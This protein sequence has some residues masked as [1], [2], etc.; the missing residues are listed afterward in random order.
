[1]GNPL[2]IGGF[3]Q[4]RRKMLA[5]LNARDTGSK[6]TLAAFRGVSP[7]ISMRVGPATRM[8]VDVQ[9]LVCGLRYKKLC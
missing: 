7:A 4:M 8:L 1:M 3:L 6:A 9:I 5:L 2:P